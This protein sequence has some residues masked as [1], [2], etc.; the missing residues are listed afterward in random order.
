[1]NKQIIGIFGFLFLFLSCVSNKTKNDTDVLPTS[2]IDKAVINASETINRVLPAGSTVALF[3]NSIDENELTNFVIE[4]IN[5][6]LVNKNNLRIVERARIENLEIEHKWQMETGYVSDD[7]IT[8][9]VQK[10]GAQYVVSCYITGNGNLQRLRIKSWDLK[11]GETLSSSVFP[12]NEIGEQLVKINNSRS[13]IEKQLI[14]ENK[15]TIRNNGITVDYQEYITGTNYSQTKKMELNVYID[16]TMSYFFILPIL[17]INNDSG[18]CYYSF[19]IY[20]AKWSIENW[21]SVS[22]IFSIA[23]EWLDNDNKSLIVRW[24]EKSL[25]IENNL[26]IIE[27]FNEKGIDRRTINNILSIVSK[28][29]LDK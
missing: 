17:T 11:T 1:M 21:S 29:L 23:R 25:E 16:G 2:V 3:N 15:K 6:I 9:I 13:G 27:C 24:T 12:T 20:D 10:L 8:S 26:D 4:E 7:E 22:P 5:S 19:S 14:N 18:V 28:I